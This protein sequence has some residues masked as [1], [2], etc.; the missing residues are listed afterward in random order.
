MEERMV[1]REAAFSIMALLKSAFCGGNA[2]VVAAGVNKGR[3]R[4]MIVMRG[5]MRP[6]AHAAEARSEVT[7][8]GSFSVFHLVSFIEVSATLF[9]IL[10]A[11]VGELPQGGLLSILP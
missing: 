4:S 9:R 8:Q 6:D 10:V 11:D 5:A 1:D 3:Y 7:R 2:H